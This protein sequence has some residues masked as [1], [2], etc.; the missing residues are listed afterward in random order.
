M[1]NHHCI[2][3]KTN[4][5]YCL[6]R[7][8]P[9][10]SFQS[11]HSPLVIYTWLYPQVYYLFVVVFSYFSTPCKTSNNT[12]HHIHRTNLQKNFNLLFFTDPVHPSGGGTPSQRHDSPSQ[13]ETRICGRTFRCRKRS[14]SPLQVQHPVGKK[15]YDRPED[16]A[17]G[18]IQNDFK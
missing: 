11:Q 2:L 13:R 6:K 3:L 12:Y 5:V 8:D 9:T 15:L 1:L 14:Q 18:T 17:Q 7:G 16:S 10:G 4:R